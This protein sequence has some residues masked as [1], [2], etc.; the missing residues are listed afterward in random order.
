MC[1][2]NSMDTPTGVGS[3]CASHCWEGVRV[4]S[5]ANWSLVSMVEFSK[6]V[7]IQL[8]CTNWNVWQIEVGVG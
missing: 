8:V 5:A 2:S 7:K 4:T 3:A 6:I 1:Y